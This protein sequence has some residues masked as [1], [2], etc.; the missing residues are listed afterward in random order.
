MDPSLTLAAGLQSL[1]TGLSSH[2]GKGVP[3]P[4]LLPSLFAVRPKSE[5]GGWIPALLFLDFRHIPTQALPFPDTDIT[6][7]ANKKIECDITRKKK[8]KMRHRCIIC[9]KIE[10]ELVL[11]PDADVENGSSSVPDRRL[12]NGAHVGAAPRSLCSVLSSALSS[13]HPT[14]WGTRLE[15]TQGICGQLRKK[16]LRPPGGGLFWLSRFG[17]KIKRQKNCFS[18]YMY[19]GTGGALFDPSIARAWSSI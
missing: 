8:L 14:A 6:P 10:N 17:S 15:R 7:P 4:P 5:W 13:G 16:N 12:G 2:A 19:F 11:N 1:I 3:D 9:R 18:D